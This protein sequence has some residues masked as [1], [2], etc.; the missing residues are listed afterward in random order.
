MK[1]FTINNLNYLGF[2]NI[3]LSFEKG[4]IYF[5][6]GGSKSGKTTLLNI[7]SSIIL[8]ENILVLDNVML[9]KN[10]RGEYLKKI[11][12]VEKVNNNSFYLDSVLDELLYPLIN[13]GYSKEKSL[14]IIN[15]YL[16]IFG[17]KY[18]INNKIKKLD[19][20]EKQKLLIV[21]SLLH[22]P[23]ILLIDNALEI[24]S[25]SD[26]LDILNNLKKL[27]DDYLTVVYFSNNLNYAKYAYKIEL[28][29][30]YQYVGEYDYIDIFENDK[31]FYD[32]DIEI[33]FINDLSNK[34]KIYNLIDKNYDDMKSM[35]DDIWD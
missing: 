27:C 20:Y 10:T 1:I 32:N 5:V 34:L 9:N 31:V 4:K 2:N 3:S 16:K 12:I 23:S 18:L 28:L 17:M 29:S 11:G 26:A 6:V 33:P 14:L 13:L 15:E 24:F 21:I 7:F 8:I 22:R 35:V 25:E 19:I 30:N